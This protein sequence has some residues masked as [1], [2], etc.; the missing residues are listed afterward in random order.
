RYDLSPK[1]MPR[2]LPKWHLDIQ[3]SLQ[4]SAQFQFWWEN[5]WDI[6][7]SVYASRTDCLPG[8]ARLEARM[9]EVGG[10]PSMS[11]FTPDEMSRLRVAFDMY[12]LE[13]RVKLSA[14][15]VVETQFVPELIE[16]E[17]GF[18]GF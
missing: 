1:T 11:S 18:Q 16:T 6:A 14:T 9:A 13:E 15:D 5:L 10:E 4:V 7:V 17:T 2:E 12:R 8:A 3:N